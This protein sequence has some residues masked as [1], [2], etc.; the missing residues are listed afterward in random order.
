MVKFMKKLFFALLPALTVL[1]GTPEFEFSRFVNGA[2]K[3]IPASA[4]FSV[5]KSVK[6]NGYVTEHHLALAN[7]GKEP[8]LLRIRARFAA[9]NAGGAYWDGNLYTRN[10]KETVVPKLDR[11]VFPLTS[12]TDN[13]K[14]SVIGFAPSMVVSRFERSLEVKNGKAEL[15]FDVFRVLYPG[16]KLNDIFVSMQFDGVSYVEAVENYHLTYPAWF[17]PADGVD[18]RIYGTGGYL[19]SDSRLRDY[20]YAECRR[21]GFDWEW[22]Y[23]SYQRSGDYYPSPEFWDDKLGYKEEKSHAKCNVPGTI[24]DWERN[25]KIRTAAGDKTSALFYYYMQQYCNTDLIKHFSDSVWADANGKPGYRVKGWA[26]EFWA[27]YVWSGQAG[28]FGKKTRADLAKLWKNLTISG[29]SLDCAIGTTPY[30]GKLVKDEPFRAYDKNG[31][32]FVLEGVALAYNMNYTRNLPLRPDGRRAGSIVNAPY[33]YLPIFYCDGEMHEASAWERTDLP[34]PH[35]LMLGRKPWVLWRGFVLAPFLDWNRLNKDDIN[36]AISGAVDY[37]TLFSLRMG[38]SPSKMFMR[39]YPDMLEVKP[40]ITRL[41][42]A[43]WHAAP[44]AWVKGVDG[45]DDPWAQDVPF[46][47]SRYGEG[48]DC[49][50]VVSNPRRNSARG[51]LVIQGGKSGSPCGVY[52]D[53]SG[54]ATVNRI[55]GS[56]TL[57][58]FELPEFGYLVLKK[59][60]DGGKGTVTAKLPEMKSPFGYLPEDDSWVE[61]LPLADENTGALAAVAGKTDEL[62]VFDHLLTEL[63]TYAAYHHGRR[64]VPMPRLW[65]LR[66]V[67]KD[68]FRFPVVEKSSAKTTFALGESARKLCFPGVKA[69]DKIVYRQENGRHFVGFFPGKMSEK[70]LL[71]AFLFR[72][73]KAYPYVAA[74]MS[75]WPGKV[76]AADKAFRKNQPTLDDAMVHPAYGVRFA[77]KADDIALARRDGKLYLRTRFSDTHDLVTELISG[78]NKQ[79]EFG[80]SRRIPAGIG[81]TSD[82]MLGGERVYAAVDEAAPVMVTYGNIAG[83]HGLLTALTIT[84]PDHGFTAADTGKTELKAGARIY[85]I[86]KVVDKNTLLV[87]SENIGINGIGYF[88]RSSMK[89]SFS[90]NG[91]EYKVTK[92]IHTQLYPNSRIKKQ[93]WLLDGKPLPEGEFILRGKKLSCDE[94]Y[95]VVSPAGLMDKVLKNPGKEFEWTSADIPAALEIGNTYTFTPDGTMYIE[96]KV[97]FVEKSA[98]RQLGLLQT[99]I[100]WMPGRNPFRE[101]FIP[102][103]KE[104]ELNKVKFDFSKGVDATAKLP[105]IY[106]NESNI[107]DMNDLPERLIQIAGVNHPKNGKVRETGLVIGYSLRYGATRP[108]VRK[109]SAAKQ[110]VWINVTQ[111]SY[112]YVIQST[113]GVI[114]EAGSVVEASGYRKFFAPEKFGKAVPASYTVTENGKKLL[115]LHFAESGSVKVPAE[116]TGVLE[117]SAGTVFADGAVSGKA[118]DW[119]VLE[120]K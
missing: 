69:A 23:N 15:V 8:L 94:L 85:Y 83:N 87:M 18:K 67:F 103:T 60:S 78:L 117:K 39:G 5:K 34:V 40:L 16:E 22:Y 118:G 72:L 14:I 120:E 44:Y 46:W 66:G 82:A 98:L 62:K 27:E 59:M 32:I 119:I 75:D 48:D 100:I 3:E 76:K 80:S 38:A 105:R 50:V 88:D 42:T 110:P 108:E 70:E 81:V 35:R 114:F 74:T 37:L 92:I 19:S 58:D 90:C 56:D 11:H 30:Y 109:K 1:G 49:Y 57:I 53:L 101:Y 54:K 79:V 55:E 84:V 20:Q 51:T 52:A 95:E 6:N 17:R 9:G 63:V 47:V 104:F 111:K 71:K 102:K 61:A 10:V 41:N 91:K 4:G 77:L 21:T 97:K 116:F 13:G 73:D 29:F 26:D 112:P 45:A 28:S 24:A 36:K 64:R 68:K 106:F 2:H 107:Q 93:N 43:G 86:L 89:D 65:H 96:Q 115:Y 113:G 7:N 12:Y 25:H 33:N 31:K 99:Q